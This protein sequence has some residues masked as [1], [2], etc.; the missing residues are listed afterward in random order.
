MSELPWQA[1]DRAGALTGLARQI[2][3][4]PMLLGDPARDRQAQAGATGVAAAGRI[5]TVEALE[6]VR[7]VLDRAAVSP[8]VVVRTQTAK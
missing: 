6:D 8:R 4:A 2:D 7:Q 1:Y 3:R 5:G